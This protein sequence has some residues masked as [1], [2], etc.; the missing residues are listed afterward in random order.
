ML[1]NKVHTTWC[2]GCSQWAAIEHII[3]KYG[4]IATDN[5]QQEGSQ[6]AQLVI[7]HQGE[8]SYMATRVQMRLVGIA[9]VG[10]QERLP[11]RIGRYLIWPLFAFSQIFTHPAKRTTMSGFPF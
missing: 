4:R 6:V 1:S 8:I 9:H 5:I 2:P 7:T 3:I 10:R 11:G